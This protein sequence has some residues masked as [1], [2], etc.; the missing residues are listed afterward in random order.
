MISP[1]QSLGL[2]TSA[3]VAFALVAC[4]ESK[5]AQCKKLINVVNK[6]DSIA[7]GMNDK[8]DAATM[9]KLATDLNDLAKNI[10]GVQLVDEPL[11]GYQG[12]FVKIYT[13]LGQAAGK[14]G[15]A[16]EQLATLKKPNAETLKKSQALKADVE[17]ASKTGDKAAKEEGKLVAEV[18]KYC[19]AK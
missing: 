12:R 10:E 15:G 14:V 18:N 8:P 4:G 17:S 5:V 2:A 11:K 9:K 7:K 6:G 3:V 19:G 16:F 1:R 13:D